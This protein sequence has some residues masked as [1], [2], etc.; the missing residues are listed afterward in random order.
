MARIGV[1]VAAN[2]DRVWALIEAKNGG[3]YRSDDGGDKWELINPDHRLT[4]R[5]W[6]Y[7]HVVADPK[8]PNT[9]YV[10]NVDFHRSIDGGR[11]F[12]KIKVPH[13]DNHG[14]WIDPLNTRRMIQTDDG[15]ATV[16]VDG[17]DHWTKQDN[18]PTAQFY[19]VIA[20]NRFPYYRV[21][22]AAGQF[23]RRDCHAA[24]RKA[25]RSSARTGIPSA[26]A[27]PDTSR[28]TRRIPTSSSPATIRACSPC[29]TGAPARPRSLAC[30][31]PSATAKAPP[32][33]NI[34]SSGRRR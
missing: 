10:L 25:A 9:V 17:G 4:Q 3:L 29:S 13:G 1:A 30:R 15:G 11:T 28:H 6:Y 23:Q 18:Q 8:D 7:M 33:S 31:L 27:R 32:A 26:A 16:T 21:R 20:D 5:A 24:A 22:I 34:A 19:H 2:S 12:N 14:L